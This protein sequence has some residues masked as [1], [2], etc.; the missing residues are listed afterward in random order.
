M[1]IVLLAMVA[2]FI[3]LRLRSEL[4]KKTGNEP[5][6]P[7]AGRMHPRG[8]HESLEDNGRD[9]VDISVGEDNVIDMEEN[10]AL[11][12]A[13]QDIRHAD[14]SFDV[15]TFLT[16]AKAAYGM[17]LEAFWAG[18]KETLKDF[19]DDGVLQQFSAAVDLREKDGLVI[20]N[21]LLDVTEL[22]IIGAQLV[23]RVAELTVHFRAEII[24]VTK[25]KDGNVVEGNVSDAVEVNDKWTFARDTKSREPNWALVATRAG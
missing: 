10:P 24:A 19:L 6:P 15:S 22:D 16:G 12:K 20:H 1:E 25:D 11:R 23:G 7:A 21:Q 14:R 4:G 9:T 18:D 13:F 17:I 8:S 3:F 2:A 5:L